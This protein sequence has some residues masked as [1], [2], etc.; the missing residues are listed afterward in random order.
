MTT[1]K[2]D[3]KKVIAPCVEWQE[4]A[5]SFVD[6]SYECLWSDQGARALAW[7]HQRGLEDEI[8]R[9]AQ[10]GFNPE[11]MREYRE[12]WGLDTD[13][14]KYIKLPSGI[15]IP[16]FFGTDIFSVNIRRSPKCDGPKYLC[17]AGS[18]KGPYYLNQFLNDKPAMLLEGEFDVLTI[19]QEASDL[20]LPIATGGT[21]SSRGSLV[22][23]LMKCPKVL[24]TFDADEAGEK[25]RQWWLNELPNGKYWRPYFGDVNA[26]YMKGVDIR[27]WIEEGLD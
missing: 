3:E 8:I 4:C 7:L 12:D 26:M 16:R 1:A 11:N 23:M 10:L 27:E 22:V 20:V 13:G 5:W 19:H 9:K 17:L 14:K 6:E 15:V 24:V 2:V 25:A 21:S 18:I